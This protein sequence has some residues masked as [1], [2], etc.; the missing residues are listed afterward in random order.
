M[1]GLAGDVER[2]IGR[3]LGDEEPLAVAVS[4]GP[5]SLALLLLAHAAFGA[6]VRALTVDHGLRPE[7]AD[8]AAG[9]AAICAHLGVPHTTLPWEGPKPTGNLQAAARDARYA[10]MS[11]WCVANG[12]V[13]LVTAHHADDQAETLLLRLARGSGLAGLA[14]VRVTRR[15]PTG[16]TLLRPL[17][18]ARR[19]D[20]AAVVLAAGLTA[21]DDPSNHNARFDRTHARRWL[22]ALPDLDAA[23]LAASAAH[24]AEAE[25]ALAWTADLAWAGR[26]SETA[27]ELHLDAADLPRELQR[28]LLIRALK[29]LAAP[30][31]RGAEIDRLL[32]ALQAGETATLGGIRAEGGR[33]WRFAAAPPR[34]SGAESR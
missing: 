20:L 2:L 3:P 27:G 23:G 16:V 5:D 12:I 10:L 28:R 25:A 14:G 4:G 15:L 8:E 11:D 29:T 18:D 24:L 1:R 26:A 7:G 9:V 33:I 30:E 31:S 32:A 34:R 19:A 17:L 6:R 21:A 13:W 22:A